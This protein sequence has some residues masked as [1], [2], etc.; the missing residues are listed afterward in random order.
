MI[1]IVL[2]FTL[3]SMYLFNT[4]SYEDQTCSISHLSR[5]IELVSLVYPQGY[6]KFNSIEQ[7]IALFIHLIYINKYANTYI[8]TRIECFVC[9]V[10]VFMYIRV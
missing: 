1:V 6:P 2:K 3:F 7:A 4:K 8:H 9:T 10:V 5:Q